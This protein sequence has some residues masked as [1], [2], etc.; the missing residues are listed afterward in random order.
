MG[1]RR[2]AVHS[3]APVPKIQ[4]STCG[5]NAPGE[6]CNGSSPQGE[7]D[8]ENTKYVAVAKHT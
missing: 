4:K 7:I 8:C 2:Y 3:T 1:L 6:A 5:L